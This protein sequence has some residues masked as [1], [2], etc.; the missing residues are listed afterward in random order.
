VGGEDYSLG[1]RFNPTIEL[2]APEYLTVDSS[3]KL[4]GLWSN[5][6]GSLKTV[7][8]FFIDD[9]S[10]C[11]GVNSSSFAGCGTIGGSNKIVIE[12]QDAV[13]FPVLLAHE[14]GHNLNM[15][16]GDAQNGDLMKLDTANSTN[17]NLDDFDNYLGM[18]PNAV[19]GETT[20]PFSGPI[21]GSFE[22]GLSRE[23]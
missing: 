18:F 19:L 17:I 22:D 6:F 13:D 16:H 10:F 14:L 21:Q 9:L 3:A 2:V 23:C 15:I 5:H 1:I 8:A 20:P 7:N 4:W 11:G 12:S